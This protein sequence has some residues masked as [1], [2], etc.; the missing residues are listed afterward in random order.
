M[1]N[2]FFLFFIL[3]SSFLSAANLEQENESD[4]VVYYKDLSNQLLVKIGINSS[5]SNLTIKNTHDN[6]ELIIKP[7]G[8]VSLAAAVN[9][10]WFGLGVGIG[11][12]PNQ[13]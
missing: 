2:G 1:K 7:L 8:Q 13:L 9:Y 11:L 10:K 6:R 12:P 4:S 3:L 5:F